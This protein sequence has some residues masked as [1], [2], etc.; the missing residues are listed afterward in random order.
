ME[1][2]R[3]SSSLDEL[4]GLVCERLDCAGVLITKVSDERQVILA[5]SGI[6]LPSQYA[7]SMPLSHS[8]CQHTSA[9]D[10]PLVI[11]DVISHPLL[12]SNLS[13]A[14]LGVAAYLGAPV[15]AVDGGATGALCAVEVRQR[16]WVADDIEL[17]VNA[18]LVADHLLSTGTTRP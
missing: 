8:I 16:R 11:D 5:N 2:L 10:F 9:M 17:V 12:S 14:D 6:V 15:H 1:A 13:F 4:V 18:A 3:N 7:S